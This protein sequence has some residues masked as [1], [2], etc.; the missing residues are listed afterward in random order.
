MGGTLT[1]LRIILGDQ[2]TSQ[3]SSLDGVDPQGDIILMC[4]VFAEATYVKHHKKKIAFIFSAMRHFAD[5]LRGIGYE[6]VYYPLDQAKPIATFTQAVEKTLVAHNVNQIIVT[7]PGEHRVLC[8]LQS[9]SDTFNLPVDIRADTRFLCDH[10][11][12]ETWSAERKSLRMEYFYRDMRKKYSILMDGD[13][14]VGGQWNFDSDNRK[15]PQP[16]FEVPD[17]YQNPPNEITKNV[18]SLVETQFPSHMGDTTEFHFAVTAAQAKVA[19]AQF[20]EERLQYFGDFQDAMIQ[21]KPWM[22]HAHIGLYLNVGLLLPL[23]CISAAEQAYYRKQAP[24]NA[25]EGF[26]RQIL[27][28]REF[29][30][31]IYWQKMPSYASLNF[32]HAKQDLPAFYWNAE[33]KMNCLHQSVKETVENAYAH[34]IQRL[35]VLGN[36]ALLAGIDPRQVNDWFLSVYA[37]AFEWVE[38]PNVM[39]MALFADG[40]VLA[41]KPYASGG[42]YIKKMSNYCKDC[43][44]KVTEKNGADA[45]PFNY[46]YWDFL[47]R[48]RDKLGNNH[49]VGMMYKVYDRMDDNKKMAIHNDSAK[50]LKNLNALPSDC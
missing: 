10:A 32:F 33:T 28:W 31:G 2:L 41:S 26:I 45:C 24:L 14:P 3:I 36:F 47:D 1:T 44:Y 27:G 7:E 48:N 46:L 43:S 19:L 38:M 34:H 20:I 11:E 42:G 39:G 30:R 12:F 35:M 40:G 22:Y 18:L 8:E 15:P 21:G 16:S 50:F 5:E 49:R 9:W 17:T 25:V 23:E 29:V 37:D 13:Q 6:V 4:E